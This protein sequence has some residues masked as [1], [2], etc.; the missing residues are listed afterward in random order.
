MRIILVLFFSVCTFGICQADNS[1]P[2]P[3]LVVNGSSMLHK[4]ADQVTM[5]ISVISQSERAEDALLDNNVGI[6]KVLDSIKSLGIG[7][8]EYHTGQFSINPVHSQPPRNPPV[9]WKQ[10][11]LAYQVTNTLNIKTKQ[12][13]LTAAIIDAAGK[14]GVDQ[15]SNITFGIQDPKLYRSEAIAEATR[16][17][18]EDATTIAEI[19]NLKIVRI[20]DVKLDQPQ[21]YAR[22][23]PNMY[24]MA[25]AGNSAPFIEAA[26]VDIS[27]NVSVIFEVSSK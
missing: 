27:A 14:N 4:P 13:E 26:D 25:K 21:L 18:L 24:Y 11:I 22:P 8:G 20:L 6:Q 10:T 19:A 1:P 17:A 15:V 5:S 16:N 23:G 2:V 3:K 7:K 12:I 9:D